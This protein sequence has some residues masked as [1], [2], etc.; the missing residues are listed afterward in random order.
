MCGFT[1]QHSSPV[2][3]GNVALRRFLVAKSEEAAPPVILVYRC[4]C[5]DINVSTIKIFLLLLANHA[6]MI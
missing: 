3:G 4:T 6:S 2:G 1:E 5:F